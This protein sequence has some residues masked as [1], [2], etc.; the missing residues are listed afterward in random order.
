MTVA[1]IESSSLA[2]AAP[3]APSGVALALAAIGPVA[4]GGILAAKVGVASPLAAA[5][6]IVFGVIGATSPALYI[7]LAAVGAAPPIG[8]VARAIVTSLGAFGVALAGLLL[9]AAF[10]SLSSLSAAT[11]V[12]VTSAALVGAAVIGMQRLDRE[13]ARPEELQRTSTA[14]LLYGVWAVATLGIA[15]RLW[16]NL[17]QEV[18]L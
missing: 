8:R 14:Q 6:A 10:L 2:P 11:T 7:A 16:W 15:A 18:M 1:A 12:V 5:P 9:P 4:V 17:V 3:P 13:L